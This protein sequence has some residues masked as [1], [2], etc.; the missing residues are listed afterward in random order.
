MTSS[1]MPSLRYRSLGFPVRLSKGSTAT[2]ATSVTGAAALV[3]RR[4]GCHTAAMAARTTSTALTATALTAGPATRHSGL[5]R[6]RAGTPLGVAIASSSV[7]KSSA[8]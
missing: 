1:V 2:D 5:V 6:L 3:G 8:L 7:S 4:Q